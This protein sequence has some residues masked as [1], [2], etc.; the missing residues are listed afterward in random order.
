MSVLLSVKNLRSGYGHIQVLHDVS[1][2]LPLSGVAAIIGPNGHGKTT[3]LR[4]ISGLNRTWAGEI[5]FKGR[6]MP[7]KAEA[8][9]RAG[10]IHVPQGDQLFMEMTVAEN[11]KMGAYRRVGDF[12]LNSSFD[13]VYELFPQ[14]AERRSQRVSSL[15]GGER[16][17]V[18]I[19]RGMMAEGKLLMIDEPSLGLAPIT[20]EQVYEALERLAET[21][22]AILVVEENPSRVNVV[23]SRF[24]LMDGGRF[25]WSG[26]AEELRTSASFVSTYLGE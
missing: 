16:R 6:P 12:D 5:T 10:L 3:L 19:G 26:N 7:V 17:M 15:S 4:T 1:F 21:G 14:I 22:R 18:G 20:I 8:R 25:A 11:L 13:H 2:E 24:F 9:T 23:A